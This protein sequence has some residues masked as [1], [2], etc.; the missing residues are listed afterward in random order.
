MKINA[1]ATQG[2][3]DFD[4]WVTSYTLSYSEDGTK[5]SLYS[6]GGH[7]KVSEETNWMLDD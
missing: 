1:L 2:R 6:V 7:Q 3:A 5:Y 4:Q